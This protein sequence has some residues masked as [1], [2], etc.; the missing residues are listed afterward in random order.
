MRDS[1]AKGPAAFR[2]PARVNWARRLI[3]PPAALVVL[4]LALAVVVA[5]DRGAVRAATV[6]VAHRTG[7]TDPVL[8]LQ[9]LRYRQFTSLRQQF[10]D[11]IPAGSTVLPA[12]TL[13]DVWKQRIAEFAVLRGARVVAEPAA[14][15]YRVRVLG[16]AAPTGMPTLVSERLR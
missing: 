16:P 4:L 11:Q 9:G 12:P 1:A 7:R 14:A 13:A 5:A 10:D 15:D 2:Y 8:D 6:A 3:S